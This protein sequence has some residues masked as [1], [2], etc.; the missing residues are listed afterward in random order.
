MDEYL[1]SVGI[2]DVA[3]VLAVLADMGITTPA[4]WLAL[5]ADD[6]EEAVAGLKDAKVSLGDMSKM[7]KAHG[8]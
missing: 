6:R 8:T 5:D 3:A 1:R 7:K 2:D 4:G